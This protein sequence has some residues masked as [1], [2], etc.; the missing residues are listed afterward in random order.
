MAKVQ[1]LQTIFYVFM[2][3]NMTGSQYAIVNKVKAPPSLDLIIDG[4]VDKHYI[5]NI[6]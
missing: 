6:C 1:D 3:K 5:Y 2:F 4:N